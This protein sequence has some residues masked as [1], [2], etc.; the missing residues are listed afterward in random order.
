MLKN[1]SGWLGGIHISRYHLPDQGQ[2]RTAA[3]WDSREH[4]SFPG[5]V[6]GKP[7]ALLLGSLGWSISPPKS[8][9]LWRER[10]VG[11][12]PQLGDPELGGREG[13]SCLK[14]TVGSVGWKLLPCG[15]ESSE[16]RGHLDPREHTLSR[17]WRKH[18]LHLPT[19]ESQ[20]GSKTPEMISCKNS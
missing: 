13:H 10:W 4:V 20:E 15:T 19:R 12:Q 8:S 2:E 11:P 17:L 6:S 14:A 5:G 18:V 9:S 1:D 3:L 7:L 16:G